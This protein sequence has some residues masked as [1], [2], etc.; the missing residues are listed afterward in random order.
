MEDPPAF[1]LDHQRAHRQQGAGAAAGLVPV[2]DEPAALAGDRRQAGLRVDGDREADGF[3]QR[4]IARRVGV[5]D[6]LV[7]AQPLGTAVVVEQL[8]PRLAGRRHLQHLARQRAVGPHAHLGGDDLVEQRAQP[9]D[10][11]VEARP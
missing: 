2:L 5:G 9:L 8:R 10:G 6:G 3:Q 11:E 1:A 7:D 4:E